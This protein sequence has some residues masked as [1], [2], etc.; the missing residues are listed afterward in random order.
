MSLNTWW[1]KWWPRHRWLISYPPE[2]DDGHHFAGQNDPASDPFRM[3]F[4]A[5]QNY[6]MRGRLGDKG[7]TEEQL[8]IE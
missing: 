4:R 7:V 8:D 3:D 5:E 2:V 6:N 1:K